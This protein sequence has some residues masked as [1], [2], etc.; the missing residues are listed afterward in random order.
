MKVRC[1]TCGKEVEI[2]KLHKDYTKL[3]EN[4]KAAFICEAC[5]HKIGHAARRKKTREHKWELLPAAAEDAGY[6]LW[7]EIIHA[8][9]QTGLKKPYLAF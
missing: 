6:I 1:M 7:K 5:S 2:S 3:A 4:P 8:L 9:L